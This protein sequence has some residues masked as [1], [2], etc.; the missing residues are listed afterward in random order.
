MFSFIDIPLD[1]VGAV[2]AD[3]G[4]VAGGDTMLV[5]EGED[6]PYADRGRGTISDGLIGDLS[7][8]IAPGDPVCDLGGGTM[9]EGD[10][11]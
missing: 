7:P 10:G 9:T 11:P 2:G 1:R 8:Y 3:A 4:T 5:I 6:G